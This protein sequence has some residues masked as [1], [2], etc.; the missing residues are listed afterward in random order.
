MLVPDAN[1]VPVDGCS[2]PFLSSYPTKL[3]TSPLYSSGI[4]LYCS[5]VNTSLY[6]CCAVTLFVESSTNTY[7]S[8]AFFFY[9]IIVTLFLPS[10]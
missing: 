5:L 9:S 4:E 8:F 7:S 6:D 10:I 3:S 2:I 1:S